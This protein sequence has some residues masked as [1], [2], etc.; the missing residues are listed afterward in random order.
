MALQSK[1]A[2]LQ[3]GAPAAPQ[4]GANGPGGPGGPGGPEGSPEEGAASQLAQ[5]SAELHG[6]DPAGLL[7]QAQQVR[8]VIGVMG[9]HTF[10]RMPNV[11]NYLFATLKTLDR[12]IKEIQQAAQTA[13]AV[14]GP[15]NFSLADQSQPT[16]SG[17][18]SGAP[19]M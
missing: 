8:R 13:S 9:I 7:R 18:G 10:E 19:P 4:M 2:Q 5:Q 17:A 15:V 3:G 11:S 1:L 12:A 16:P 6:A 14:R